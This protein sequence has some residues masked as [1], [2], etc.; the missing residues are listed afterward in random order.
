M[1]TIRAL[2]RRDRR[3]L[4]L[5]ILRATVYAFQCQRAEPTESSTRGGRGFDLEPILSLRRRFSLHSAEADFETIAFLHQEVRSPR[6][7]ETK[8]GSKISK[9]FKKKIKK[10]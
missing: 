9:N 6:N 3:P 4:R 1:S 7:I 8:M 10:N 5:E 2:D